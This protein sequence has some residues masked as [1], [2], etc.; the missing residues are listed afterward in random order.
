LLE[1]LRVVIEVFFACLLAF[2]KAVWENVVFRGGENVVSMW[3]SV[4]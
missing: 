2:L 1:K 3:S 4:W